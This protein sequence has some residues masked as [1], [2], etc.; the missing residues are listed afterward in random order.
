MKQSARDAY[1]DLQQYFGLRSKDTLLNAVVQSAN[2]TT[3]DKVTSNVTKVYQQMFGD[4]NYNA[5]ISEICAEIAG[6]TTVNGGVDKTKLE[7]L[8]QMIAITPWT[9]VEGI[10]ADSIPINNYKDQ[11]IKGKKV[12]A[13]DKHF[14]IVDIAPGKFKEEEPNRIDA[15]QVFP[16]A[17]VPELS[18]TDIIS[19]Y[20][21]T[22]TSL[23]MSK[24]VPYVDVTTMIKGRANDKDLYK[25][26]F[27]FGKFLGS[28]DADLDTNAGF[29]GDKSMVAAMEIFTTPQ[30]LINA[31]KVRYNENSGTGGPKDV[32]RP[33]M[34][35]ESLNFNVVAASQG[36][37]SFKTANMKIRLFD[38]GRLSDIA[39]L[40]APSQFA[41]VIFNIEYGWSHPGGNTTRKADADTDRIGQLIDSMRVKE[42]YQV[43]NSNFTFEQDGSVS[44][45]IKLMMLI[46]A[47]LSSTHIEFGDE[48][49]SMKALI[50]VLDEIKKLIADSPRK[51]TT[52]AI[53]LGDTAAFISMDKKQKAELSSYMN[54]IKSK[55]NGS[56]AI[57][58][59]VANLG[60]LI[61]PNMKDGL[62]DKLQTSRT[63][64]VD[65]FIESLKNSSDPFTRKSGLSGAA[66]GKEWGV[67][68]K[69]RQFSS[70][71]SLGSIL[72]AALG[73]SFLSHGDTIFIFT[74]FNKSA[75][76]MWDHNISQFPIR[77]DGGADNAVT[78]KSAL[79]KRLATSSAITPQG[80]LEMINTEFLR[81][82]YTEAY[83]LSNVYKV[84]ILAG[85]EGEKTAALNGEL[86]KDIVQKQGKKGKDAKS[87]ISAIEIEKAKI[88][89]LKQI[90]GAS[91]S[92]PNFTMPNVCLMIDTK[93]G[94]DGKTI[95]R[96]ILIDQ[97]ASNV[98]D[99]QQMM[100]DISGQGFYIKEKLTKPA[101]S[102]RSALHGETANAV[103]NEL[104]DPKNSL[105]EDTTDPTKILEK[106]K[107]FM[108]AHQDDSKLVKSEKEAQLLIDLDNLYFV[109]QFKSGDS[110]LRNIFYK[111]FPT[112][113]YGSM[114]SGI[115]QAQLQ[116]NQNDALTT[117]ALQ[118]NDQD[119][120]PSPGL[121]VMIHPTQLSL[122]VFGCPLFKF[123]QKFFIDFGTGTNADNFYAVTGVEMSF[124]PGT[125]KCNLKMTQ[126]DAFGKYISVRDHALNAMISI[127]RQNDIA[128]KTK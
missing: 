34:A 22:I 102:I 37:I 77:I 53:L 38:R 120:T 69:E 91:R 109:K 125:F 64:S 106:L 71:A 105:F 112:L 99:I 108:S 7:A 89:N 57:S 78:L 103:F 6:M 60:K 86:Q 87:E 101:G 74:C 54:A 47:D 24:A 93:P 30:T 123:S 1:A 122:E 70:Y 107:N 50:V 73:S 13:A 5:S 55:D 25:A 8:Q 21:S 63:Q 85:K 17:G 118:R 29:V 43:V 124:A 127:L 45:D 119:S 48:E 19:L 23:N 20:M 3:D 94:K 83:G 115:I 92:R 42:S 56:P 104:N 95:T 41:A 84:G 97:A 4:E 35:I 62:V 82:E 121:P 40:V 52:P 65:K 12:Y 10:N 49:Q 28:T 32:F 2:K 61:G 39:P 27:S 76:A 36:L 58:K 16:V 51:I 26:D 15:I 44:I 128:K 80:F 66:G 110:S 88:A 68:S 33:F 72:I 100:D 9:Y 59:V 96:V 11:G 75:G 79:L 46:A 67:D 114:G 14:S 18:D 113:I 98:G 111:H 126:L 116:S 90:Y 81:Q 117:N 31:D